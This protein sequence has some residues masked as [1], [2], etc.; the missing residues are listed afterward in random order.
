LERGEEVQQ[1]DLS[2]STAMMKIFLRQTDEATAQKIKLQQ[3]QFCNQLKK[4][5]P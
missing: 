2:H 4:L 5:M 1:K 3:E